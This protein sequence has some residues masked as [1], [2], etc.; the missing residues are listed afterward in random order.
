MSILTEA[1]ARMLLAPALMAAAAILIKSYAD[2][3]DGFSAGVVVSLA[4]AVQYLVLGA[5]RTEREM[6]L[7]R[8]APRLAVLGLLIALASGFFPLLGGEAI[9]SHEPAPGTEPIHIGTLELMTPVVFDIGVFLLVAGGLIA[10]IHHLAE[11]PEANAAEVAVP[12]ANAAEPMA[13][14]TEKPRR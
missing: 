1:V 7:L 5:R 10:L 6:P 11:P 14:E 12:D 9:F 2:V 13:T 8:H 3:G 4:I